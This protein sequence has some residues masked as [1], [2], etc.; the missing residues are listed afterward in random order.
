M[1]IRKLRDET[2]GTQ[3]LTHLNNA[4]AA[5]SP[6]IVLDTITDFLTLEQTLG[7][8]EAAQRR[9]AQLDH[10][11][12]SL[13]HLLGC[14]PGEVAITQNATR[15]WDMVFYA[16]P[17]ERGDKIL[18][19]QAEYASN[20]IAFLQR[21]KNTGAEIVVLKNDKFGQI[22]LDDLERQLTPSVKLVAINHIPTNGGL[23]QPAAE[24]GALVA[25]HPALYLLDACQSVGQLPVSVA[26]LKCDFLS[27]TS[28]K[29]LRGPRGLGFLYVKDKLIPA[30]EPP[31]LD[32]HS[33]TWTADSNFE[34]RRDAKR[35]ET[36]EVFVAGK[37]GLGAAAE[38][39]LSVGVD[40]GWKRL[41]NLANTAREK[42]AEIP[43]VTICDLGK[44]QGGIVTF[45]VKNREPSWIRDSLQRQRINVW[46]CTHRAARLDMLRRELNEVVRASFHYYNTEDEVDQLVDAIKTLD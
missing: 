36:Y 9:Q 8:Y 12:Q 3:N 24:I 33:A 19:C 31:F 14:R 35:F 1:D 4:G 41:S 15:S 7:G 46:T 20:Y 39:A 2:P 22:C 38:Y 11:Y 34:I 23:V 25:D 29:Y 32:L 18:T 16:V 27:A 17:L 43:G 42:L 5:L 13:A 6:K 30:L 28:R 10:V 40:E 21:A 37:L 45:T 44:I 26:E